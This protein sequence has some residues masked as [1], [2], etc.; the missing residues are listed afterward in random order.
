MSSSGDWIGESHEKGCPV[1]A[2]HDFGSAYASLRE[3]SFCAYDL[4]DSIEQ[5]WVA[6][7]G[8][9]KG[10]EQEERRI[11][12][13]LAPVVPLLAQA[14]QQVEAIG[15]ASP[16]S[17]RAAETLPEDPDTNFRKLLKALFLGADRLCHGVEDVRDRLND[18]QR[19]TR[20]EHEALTKII[21]DVIEQ[22]RPA[23]MAVNSPGLV[24]FP[25]HCASCKEICNEDGTCDNCL[26]ENESV[27]DEWLRGKEMSRG[28]RK[29]CPECGAELYENGC[30]TDYCGYVN[31]EMRELVRNALRSYID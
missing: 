22:C 24:W 29:L 15:W 25:S 3:L 8:D 6:L 7:T 16:A 18:R 17:P 27:R 2:G 13:V 31:D 1:G 12:A 19:H 5:G 30:C 26:A 9:K 14:C 4:R 21:K 11:C 20:S 28:T 23:V 10:D